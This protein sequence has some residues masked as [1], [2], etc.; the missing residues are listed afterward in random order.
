MYSRGKSLKA[1]EEKLVEMKE[2]I[3]AKLQSTK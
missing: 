2:I 1:A 3:I